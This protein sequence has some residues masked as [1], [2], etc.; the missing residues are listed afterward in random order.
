M[1]VELPAD[2]FAFAIPADGSRPWRPGN[3]TARWRQ[4]RTRVDLDGCRLHD[5]AEARVN[6]SGCRDRLLR[7]R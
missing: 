2:S 1:R 3:V 4:L 7:H 5:Y 6:A